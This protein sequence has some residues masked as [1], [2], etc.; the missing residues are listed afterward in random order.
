[1][2]GT[3]EWIGRGSDVKGSDMGTSDVKGASNVKANSSRQWCAF[4]LKFLTDK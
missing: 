3:S 4:G 2:M 1:M